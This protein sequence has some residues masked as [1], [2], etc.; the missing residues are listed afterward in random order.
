MSL[1]EPEKSVTSK[2]TLPPMSQIPGLGD[3][4]KVPHE[5]PSRCHRNWIKE[6]DSAYVRLA[7]QGGQ[8]DLLK[9]CAP[10]TM[11]SPPAT[12]AAPDWYL[13][14]S[15]SP[16]TDEPRSYVSS[17]PDY[18]IHKEFKPDE[19][20]GNTYETKRGPFDFDMKSVWQRDAEDKI[21]TETMK[22]KLPATS[23]KNPSSMPSVSTN[24]EFSGE[25]KLSF[26]STP[27]Q[28]KSEAVNFSKLLSNGYGTDWLQQ[29]MG[30]EKKIQETSENSEQSK[31][32]EPSQ[33]ESALASN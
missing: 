22:V 23:P 4:A 3:F 12:N 8:P 28:R 5:V 18:M 14:C 16:G 2:S 25:N 29:Y 1:K 17:L 32:S 13:H 21:K 9:H 24:K 27:A 6:T 30:Q 31:D 19:H 33:L 26:P 10:V 20:R 7:K 11:Q 15:D